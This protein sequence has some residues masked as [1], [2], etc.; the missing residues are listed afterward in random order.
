MSSAQ[1]LVFG[2]LWVAVVLLGVLVLL[3][4]REVERAYSVSPA[5]QS[6]G[7]LPGVTL[8]DLEVVENAQVILL[9]GLRSDGRFLL[10]FVKQSCD[11]CEPLLKTLESG[12]MEIRSAVIV[13]EGR[14]PKIRR[15]LPPPIEVYEPAY[16]NDVARDFGVTLVPLAYVASGGRVVATGSPT[17]SAE[18]AAL[19]ERPDPTESELDVTVVPSESGEGIVSGARSDA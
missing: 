9:P 10:V 14:T 16:P 13:L 1:A 19:L 17:S 8:P 3:L 15:A 6:A 11:R 12:K 18:L 5:R 2:I 4:Y 7:L